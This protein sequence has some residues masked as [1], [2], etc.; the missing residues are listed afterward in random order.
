MARIGGGGGS[1]KIKQP[2]R[3]SVGGRPVGERSSPRPAMPKGGAGQAKRIPVP[4]NN[5]LPPHRR[6]APNP[7]L[8]PA[9]TAGGP[10]P[11]QPRDHIE[12]IKQG[13][14]KPYRPAPV[15]VPRGRPK[16]PAKAAPAKDMRPTTNSK[17]IINNRNHPGYGKYL[18]EVGLGKAPIVAGG[19]RMPTTGAPVAG[20]GA[21]PAAPAKTPQ[22][23]IQSYIDRARDSV[24]A[25]DLPAL[26]DLQRQLETLTERYANQ[27]GETESRGVRAQSDLAELFGRVGNFQQNLKQQNQ[28]E[29][30]GSMR[31][32][33][34]IYSQLQAAI[35]GGFNQG[36]S[37]TNNELERLGMAEQAPNATAGMTRDSQYLRQLA[38]IDGTAALGGIQQN[39]Q[40]F[41]Q[42][43][44]IGRG[45][46]AVEGTVQVGQARRDME[47]RL[48]ELM[49]GY[50]EG[51]RDL[52]G[53][54]GDIIATQGE[55]MRQIAEALGD[56]DYARRQEAAQIAFEQMIAKERLG[57]DKRQVEASL[58]PQEASYEDQ[59]DVALK[60]A[61]LDGILY[62]NQQKPWE[63]K[64][65]NIL[66]AP[67]R[68]P[69]K[70]AP[71]RRF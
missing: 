29:A 31:N 34:D 49:Q 33:G 44:D 51:D 37:K 18:A 52:R 64:L 42:I 14:G 15:T 59:I 27:R 6:G 57:L 38:A 35:G 70:N 66:N 41:N 50:N 17:G 30:L 55:R 36:V 10:A 5:D 8:P 60:Q 19:G 28:G 11:K 65:R 58:M 21:K 9:L 54:R 62:E 53:Q 20:G 45:N 69:A 43:A 25:A 3:G 63:D 32:M 56:K 67:Y 71:S 61:Q 48:A 40:A 7:L 24:Q 47:S 26:N 68:S 46:T 16:A 12:A 13:V 39:Q 22:E 23:K 1:K 4:T 2:K